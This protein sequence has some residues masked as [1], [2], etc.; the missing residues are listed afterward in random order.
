MQEVAH[1]LRK[2]QGELR[3]QIFALSPHDL[4]K[5]GRLCEEVTTKQVRAL[6]ERGVDVEVAIPDVVPL[7]R[8]AL[9]LVHRVCAEALANVS[10]HAK[11]TRVAVTLAVQ[12]AE[13]ILT[14]DDDGQ[15]FSTQDIERRR[16][17]GHFGT[18]FL[19]EKA[20]VAHGTF[21]VQSEPG[22]GSHVSLSL[23]VA[24]AMTTAAP[25]AP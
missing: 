8:P 16:A 12:S 17:Q 21:A 2:V 3:T 5:P 24:D 22:S 7:D 23:P 14:I 19:A 25:Q 11:A 15:G 13:V 9:E 4:D 10:R 20:E 1:E 6:R 18:R